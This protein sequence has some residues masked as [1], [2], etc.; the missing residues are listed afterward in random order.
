MSASKWKMRGIFVL[1]VR[2]EIVT[3]ANVSPYLVLAVFRVGF[4]AGG[5]SSMF[6]SE[7]P[8]NNDN[9]FGRDSFTWPQL[10]TSYIDVDILCKSKH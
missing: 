6:I 1:I 3:K 5:G 2:V 4:I 9:L 8:A 10:N 7:A